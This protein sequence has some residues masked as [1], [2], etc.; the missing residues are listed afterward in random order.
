MS[1]EYYFHL[2]LLSLIVAQGLT[3]ILLQEQQRLS[4]TD[5]FIFIKI[6]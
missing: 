2:Q 4:Q 6:P 5:N 1:A 3:T